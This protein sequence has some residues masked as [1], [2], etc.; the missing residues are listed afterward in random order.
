MDIN[1]IIDQFAEE[2]DVK[3]EKWKET[4]RKNNPWYY[5]NIQY[6]DNTRQESLNEIKKICKGEQPTFNYFYKYFN[7]DKLEELYDKFKVRYKIIKGSNIDCIGTLKYYSCPKYT[8]KFANGKI[9]EFSVSN[10]EFVGDE[11]EITD[12]ITKNPNEASPID[13]LG[14]KTK[15]GDFVAYGS[16]RGLSIGNITTISK[17]GGLS[18]TTLEGHNI[19]ILYP[20]DLIIL[21]KDTL[22]NLMLKKLTK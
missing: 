20:K 15:I 1:Q 9:K 3:W 14:I 6:K 8:G 22:K 11:E 5:G 4:S 19:K 12:L 2:Y 18:I 16:S 17:E 21:D 10:V 13:Y 7:T